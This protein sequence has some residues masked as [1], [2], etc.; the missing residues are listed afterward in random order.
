M[1]LFY[2]HTI[3][4]STKLAVWHI[5]EPE[6]FFTKEVSVKNTVTHPHKRLQH[7]AG[8]Y[9]LKYLQPDFPFDS[10][11]IESS[12]KPVLTENQFHF[13]ISHCGDYAAAIISERKLVGIDVEIISPKIEKIKYKFL[14]S[15]ELELLQKN[16][17]S[18]NNIELITLLWSA[19][20]AL[21][22]WYG[23][24]SI[25]FKKNL[26]IKHIYCKKDR[27]LLK[28]QFSKEIVQD[29]DI[30]YRFFDSLCLVW[31]EG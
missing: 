27:G 25:S 17:V 2:Q 20:E 14:N 10:I 31:V 23:K 18:E 26:P 16:Q 29:L 3:N 13:S 30:E 4:E 5:T 6:D 11:Q 28:A 24:G 21:Y 9:L 1:P 19:K 15:H 8:R 22:K 12:K 7:L